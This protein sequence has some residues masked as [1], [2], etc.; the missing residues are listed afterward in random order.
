MQKV[1]FF[2][3]D[4]KER[5]F[6]RSRAKGHTAMRIEEDI[7]SG[8]P[9]E[10]VTEGKEL[11]IRKVEDDGGDKEYCFLCNEFGLGG[12]EG[13]LTSTVSIIYLDGNMMLVTLHKGGVLFNINGKVMM[14][15][16]G[17]KEVP[18]I[19]ANEVH[20]IDSV[21]LLQLQKLNK[22][23]TKADLYQ[24]YEF[25]MEVSGNNIGNMH[26]FNYKPLGDLDVD[27]SLGQIAIMLQKKKQHEEA[28]QAKK[29]YEQIT[30]EIE[31]DTEEDLWDEEE[32]EEYE[33]DDEWEE[34]WDD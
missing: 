28:R 19:D 33:D 10:I 29:L 17:V 16:V 15:T 13:T 25:Y 14:P 26:L 11:V 7:E 31:D 6:T 3:G 12:K 2:A 21:H 27:L 18:K 24:D 32:E 8:N 5:Y 30:T 34:D 4:V 9:V 1:F 23:R 20:W 22:D